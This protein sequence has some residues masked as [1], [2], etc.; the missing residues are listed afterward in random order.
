M[1]NIIGKLEVI[2]K[3]AQTELIFNTVLSI[4]AVL[5]IFWISPKI[6]Y[7]IVRMFKP[8]EK[9]K[10]KIK[11]HALFSLLTLLIRVFAAVLGFN[12][13]ISSLFL[14]EDVIALCN[15][16]FSVVLT[17][18]ITWGIANT[19]HHK[20]LVVKKIAG[21]MGKDPDD[22]STKLIARIIKTVIYIVSFFVILR[23]LEFDVTKLIAGL[24]IGGVIITL[25]AQ[26]T[27]KSLFAGMMIF[28]DRP[29]K[30]NDFI[31]VGTNMGTVEDIT[32]RS[33]RIRT[34]DNSILHIPN[35]QIANTEVIN[36]SSITRR[37]YKASL[38]LELDTP[39]EKVELARYKIE[40][41]VK[42]YEEVDNESVIVKF[43]KISP[44][45]IDIDVIGYIENPDYNNYLNVKEEMNY[46]ILRI[47]SDEKVKLAV[48]TSQAIYLKK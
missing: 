8:R 4:L 3:M 21:N 7:L 27:A 20:S 33:V 31:Q 48:T 13:I 23:L 11:S 37:R 2:F 47:L 28:L 18:V 26:D 6:S 32:F 24:G 46:N 45:G 10:K 44:N 38:T 36:V 39:L 42:S 35:S 29:F 40:E 14:E 16:I 41:M 30:V 9:N 5:A 15:K 1:S 25:A 22:T 34:L 12:V 43:D 19:I 17:V